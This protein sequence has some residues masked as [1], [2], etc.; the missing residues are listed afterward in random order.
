MRFAITNMATS[1]ALP[2]SGDTGDGRDILVDMRELRMCF[3]S[4]DIPSAGGEGLLLKR[5]VEKKMEV[6]RQSVEKVENAAYGLII[7][8]RER[9]KG[10]MPDLSEKLEATEDY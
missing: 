2:R 7:R 4:L 5:N 6:M 9:P 8:G 1:G 10:W 3:E